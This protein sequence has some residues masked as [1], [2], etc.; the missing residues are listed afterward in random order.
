MLH[1]AATLLATSWNVAVHHASGSAG[2]VRLEPWQ[3]INLVGSVL[4]ALIF[5]PP[6]LEDIQAWLHE[7]NER[8]GV[9]D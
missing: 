3:V 4:L 6:V 5:L 2:A 7:R 8:K 9:G 1:L